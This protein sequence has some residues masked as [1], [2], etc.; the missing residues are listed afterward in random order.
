MFFLCSFLNSHPENSTNQLRVSKPLLVHKK[1]TGGTIQAKNLEMVKEK[2]TMGYPFSFVLYNTKPVAHQVFLILIL[3][4]I[5][6]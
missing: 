6:V 4:K 5:L 1:M 2:K 3:I